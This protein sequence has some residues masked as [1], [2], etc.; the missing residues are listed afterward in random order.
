ML[1]LLKQNKLLLLLLVIGVVVRFYL[2]WVGGCHIP[3]TT[4]EALTVLQAEEVLQGKWPLLLSAQ[5]YMFPLEA[6]WMAP[7]VRW[8]PRSAHGMRVL[9]LLEGFVYTWLA[10]LLMNRLVGAHRRWLPYG[11]MLVLFP[12]IYLLMNQTAYSQPHNNSAFILALA[13]AWFVT[14]L[15]SESLATKRNVFGFAFFGGFL[16]MFAFSNAM[17]SLALVVPLGI[18]ALW[19]SIGKSRW[20]RIP[21][22]ALGGAFGLIP[23]LAGMI[24]YPGAHQSVTATYDLGKAVT[25]IWNPGVAYTL[26]V[27][28]GF[29]PCYFPD[30][31]ERL[32]GWGN[33]GRVVLPFGFIVLL[34][35]A[36][37]LSLWR[38]VMC[39]L[40]KKP[41]RLGFLE[42]SI[43]VT[44]LSLI[45]FGMSRRA[46]SGAYRYLAPVVVVF[47]FLVVMI[48]RK[49]QGNWF[50]FSTSLL[51]M[52]SVYHFATA[53]RLPQV[54]RME[55]FARDV[56]SAPDLEPVMGLLEQMGIRHAVASHWAAYRIGFFGNGDVIC[57][58]PQNERFPGWPLPYKAEVDSATNVAYVLTEHIRFLKPSIF[59]RH[60]KTMGVEA[61]M[62]VAGDFRVYTSFRSPRFDNRRPI[63]IT[64]IEVSAEAGNHHQLVN[65]VDKLAD[66]YWRSEQ[67]QSAG[68]SLIFYL[69]EPIEQGELQLRYGRYAHDAVPVKR[70]EVLWNG[71]W[72]LEHDHHE[73]TWDKFA[74]QNHHPVYGVAQ[75]RVA[76]S[77]PAEAVRLT[78]VDPRDR[79]CWTLTDVAVYV[80]PELAASEE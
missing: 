50:R 80:A 35:V 39:V 77:R 10:L 29:T 54:W 63:V 33:L 72:E 48:F 1:S 23:Y 44:L 70:V 45:L 60:L 42:W 6:Y 68:M 4:D 41:A 17:L 34:F 20:I 18:V 21:A 30:S 25:R 9:V 3:V 12:S 15:E 66:T 71:Q 61:D 24:R 62:H 76:I 31:A 16:G 19:N 74:W 11:W 53:L 40:Q 36:V 22:Y 59:E 51:I 26:P 7:M 49:L 78:I 2:Y 13:S 65:M 64:N 43:G 14:G 67:L 27:T 56:V 28:F 37:V 79:M 38:L 58:Q 32:M 73:V 75:E 55:G 47:P 52:I 57:S 5:P 46:D 8:L 69:E